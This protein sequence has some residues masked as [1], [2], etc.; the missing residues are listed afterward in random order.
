[1]MSTKVTY[2]CMNYYIDVYVKTYGP[3]GLGFPYKFEIFKMIFSELI[4]AV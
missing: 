4:G 1:M 3:V 2:L